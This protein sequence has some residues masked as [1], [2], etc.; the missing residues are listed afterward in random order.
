MISAGL[1]FF[2]GVGVV[3]ADEHEEA[4]DPANPVEIFACTFNDGM[5]P[6]DLKG[7][8]DKLNSWADKRNWTEYSAWTLMKHYAGAAQEFD[9][10]WVGVSPSAKALGRM[11]DQYLAEGTKVQDAFNEVSTCGAHGNF[12]SLTIQQPPERTLDNLVVSFSDCNMADGM[13]F[14]DVYPA[15]D[16][17]GKYR[18]SHGSKAGMWVWFPA[19]GD[20]ASDFDFKLITAYGNL[21]EQGEDWDQYSAAGWEKAAEL[22][23]GK[24]KCDTSRVYLATNH[25]RIPDD[26]E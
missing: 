9:F 3:Q 16:E 1:V 24:L 7:P 18:K 20:G 8:I 17:W 19:Y 5:G 15:L 23:P 6:A 26:E 22:F 2:A 12:A 4:S 21:E 13:L 25:R 10:L 14:G 11:Q